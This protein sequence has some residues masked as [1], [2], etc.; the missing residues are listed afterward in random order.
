MMILNIWLRVASDVPELSEV[1]GAVGYKVAQ[2]DADT[3][4]KAIMELSSYPIGKDI[5]MK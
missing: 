5:I 3:F 1:I 4:S 2:M